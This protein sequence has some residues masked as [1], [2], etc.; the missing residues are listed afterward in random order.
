MGENSE[1]LINPYQLLGVKSTSTIS[2]VKRNYYNLSLL[3]HPD[4]GGSNTDFQVVHLAY[5]YIKAQLENIRAVTYEELEEE[6]ANFCM[7]QESQKPPESHKVSNKNDESHIYKIP[8]FYEVNLEANDWLNEFNAKFDSQTTDSCDIPNPLADG[9]GTYMDP[10][11]INLD[12]VAEKLEGQFIFDADYPTEE[13]LKQQNQFKGEIVAFKEPDFTPNYV[14]Y[15]P[16]DK[17]KITDFSNLEGKLKSSDYKLAHSQII[18]SSDNTRDNTSNNEY[19]NLET[20]IKKIG[21]HRSFNTF[22]KHKIEYQADI[23]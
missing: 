7:E 21:S 10:S 2:D 22:P 18:N 19:Q 16:L 3:T 23:I 5:Q 12:N 8:T 17:T 13:E 15:L 6:F 11:E 4:K 1:K 14:K 20:E 9:Y